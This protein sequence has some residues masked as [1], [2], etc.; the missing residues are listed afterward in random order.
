MIHGIYRTRFTAN[1][2]DMGGGIVVID[3]TTVHGG[4]VDYVYTGHYSL[5]SL[6][7]LAATV[8]VTNYTGRLNAFL[9][10]RSS[11]ALSIT[12]MADPRTMSLWGSVDGQ[13]HRSIQLTLTRIGSLVDQ[14]MGC[15]EAACAVVA[16]GGRIKPLPV[17]EGGAHDGWPHLSPEGSHAPDP[18]PKRPVWRASVAW[19]EQGCC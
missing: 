17:R 7:R 13:E 16:T 18:E 5:N 19:P 15:F 1:G 4:D 14:S 8:Q 2:Q 9:G 11:F 6:H 3:E 12:G 10:R